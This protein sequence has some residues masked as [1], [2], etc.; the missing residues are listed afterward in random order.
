MKRSLKSSLIL[1]KLVLDWTNRIL[2]TFVEQLESL[3]KWSI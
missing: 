1:I 3:F 2:L